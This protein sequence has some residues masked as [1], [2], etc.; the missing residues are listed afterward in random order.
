MHV[1]NDEIQ[2]SDAHYTYFQQCGDGYLTI[3]GTDQCLEAAGAFS[4]NQSPCQEWRIITIGDYFFQIK[5]ICDDCCLDASSAGRRLGA[6]GEQRSVTCRRC[7]TVDYG[8]LWVTWDSPAICG[9][10][11]CIIF[12]PPTRRPTRWPTW[13]PT[14]EQTRRPTHRPTHK[15]TRRPTRRPT[16]RP[17][18]E[19][20]RRPTRSPI[21]DETLR[22]TAK[23]VKENEE[24]V[25]AQEPEGK[26]RKRRFRSLIGDNS[27]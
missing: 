21:R 10:D 3:E 5:N 18:R 17:T 24:E 20:T 13:S 11:P 8:Q 23:A 22:P 16:Y 14:R 12:P 6:V 15:E 25:Q 1:N 2:A 19:E 9:S 7:D 26:A 27:N 4:C